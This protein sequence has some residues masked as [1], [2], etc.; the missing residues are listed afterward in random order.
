MDWDKGYDGDSFDVVI[1]G[2]EDEVRLIS[3]D[4]PEWR[5]P[6]REE[7]RRFTREFIGNKHICLERDP[8]LSNRDRRDR[9]LRYVWVDGLMLNSEL[10]SLG[11]AQ[12]RVQAGPPTYE[13][14]FLALQ[15]LAQE[16]DLG[17]WALDDGCPYIGNKSTK[18]LHYFTCE[19]VGAMSQS[20]KKC[21][22]SREQALFEGY[23]PHQDSGWRCR[24]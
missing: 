5:K 1:S 4:A 24:P 13:T 2:E 16:A 14:E 23:H 20:N 9:L 17:L 6:F 12:V 21:F 22:Q 11:Y 7:A 8:N 3:A 18:V 15:R 19:S 10:I